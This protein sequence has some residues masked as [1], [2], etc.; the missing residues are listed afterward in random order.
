[1]GLILEARGK[2]VEVRF[3]GRSCELSPENRFGV[4]C[5]PLAVETWVE[6]GS[7]PEDLRGADCGYLV[8]Q[9]M[10]LPELE[11]RHVI[12]LHAAPPL[13]KAS[14]FFREPREVMITHR[15]RFETEEGE[16]KFILGSR[17]PGGLRM[18]SNPEEAGL[19]V[20]A[21]LDGFISPDDVTLIGR[22]PIQATAYETETPDSMEV[23]SGV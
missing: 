6:Q 4:I 12:S 9:E 19:F 20:M 13:P 3:R 1:M 23:L 11:Y 5:C 8:A 15:L 14:F 2:I 7:G 17:R 16:L 21:L 18:I 22:W 10:D